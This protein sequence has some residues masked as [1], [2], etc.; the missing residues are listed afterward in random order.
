MTAKTPN[1]PDRSSS[2]ETAPTDA[3]SEPDA[4]GAAP[5]LS[6]DAAGERETE[7]EGSLF[8]TLYYGLSLPERTARSITALAGGL[9]HES[10]AR[11]LPAAF[12]SSKSYTVF[13]QQALDMA[14]HDFGGVAND[15]AD[16][17]EE[18]Q[19]DEAFLARKAV[20]GL[21]DVAGVATLHLSPMTVL[22]I[23]S[24]VAYGSGHYLQQ[25]SAELKAQGVIDE[26]SAVDNVAGLL[27][28]LQKATDQ[29]TDTLDRPPINV[30]G[31]RQTIQQ[32]RDAIRDIDPSS[33]IPQSEITRLWSEMEAAATQSNVSI[34][35]VSATMTLFALNRVSLATRGALST[36]T[37]AG[38]L[39]DQHILTHYTDALI[40]IR[41][42]GL[43]QTLRGASAPYLEAVWSN[44]A[45][46]RTTWTEDLL[47]GRLVDKTLNVV[48]G[49][50]STK[51]G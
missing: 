44:F 18:P 9:V 15:Q 36:I 30:E 5:G 21:L 45:G 23:F 51:T 12:R 29:A 50:W 11:L 27:A 10:A 3:V 19:T 7:A 16:G 13:V 22:A 40:E 2:Q 49:W 38:N 39:L 37:V 20:G 25:L 26:Q 14:V 42:V 17:A 35:D 48:R 31:L 28:A 41:T 4:T 34:L 1:N 8:D 32:T 24:D 33:V 6:N 47:S 43:Y 46:D